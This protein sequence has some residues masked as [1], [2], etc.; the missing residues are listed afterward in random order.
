[1]II[2]IK[3]LMLFVLLLLFNN[4]YTEKK[5]ANLTELGTDAYGLMACASRTSVEALARLLDNNA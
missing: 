5:E 2:L 3:I 1:M 4:L